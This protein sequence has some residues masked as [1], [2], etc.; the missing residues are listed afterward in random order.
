MAEVKKQ[1]QQQQQQQKPQQAKPKKTQELKPE[2]DNYLIYYHDK[3]VEVHLAYGNTVIKLTGKIKTKA[4]YDVILDFED[5]Q[6]KKRRLIINK[7]YIIAVE[8]LE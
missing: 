7:G 6:G 5:E 1:Q 8:P 3:E 4:R 2:R